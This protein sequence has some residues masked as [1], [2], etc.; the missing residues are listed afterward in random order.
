MCI[1]YNE[2]GK[3]FMENEFEQKQE[4]EITLSGMSF[5]LKIPL[6]MPKPF[7]YMTEEELRNE[8]SAGLKDIEEGKLIPAKQFFEEFDKCIKLNSD[9]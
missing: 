1:I 7:E 6:E 3:T 5:D 8:I 2:D 4:K 9:V